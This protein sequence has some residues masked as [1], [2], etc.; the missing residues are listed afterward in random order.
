MVSKHRKVIQKPLQGEL[1]SAMTK[2]ANLVAC[3]SSNVS[4]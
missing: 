2:E 4:P 1:T 3:W